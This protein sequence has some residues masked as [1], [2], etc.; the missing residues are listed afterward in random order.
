M[1]PSIEDE[2]FNAGQRWG[3]KDGL[4][5][6]L[7][8]AAEIQLEARFGPLKPEVRQ[9]L[10]KLTHKPMRQLLLALQTAG[11]LKELGLED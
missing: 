6:G 1:P 4:V 7:G 11:S 10:G 8:Q 5:F 3:F 9:R 2:I